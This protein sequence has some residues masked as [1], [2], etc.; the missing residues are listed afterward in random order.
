MKGEKE[1]PPPTEEEF[2]DILLDLEMLG[3]IK[4]TDKGVLIPREFIERLKTAITRFF[5]FVWF[6]R[7]IGAMQRLLETDNEEILHI[8]VISS[9]LADLT[10]LKKELLSM[11][12]EEARTFSIDYANKVAYVLVSILDSVMNKY[13]EVRE[14]LMNYIEI[15]KDFFRKVIEETLKS[16]S[17]KE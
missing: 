4:A 13:K 17:K 16:M 9:A 7:G 10:L 1:T 12:L 8:V 3:Y 2:K 6:E 15:T 11:D 14:E 5:T